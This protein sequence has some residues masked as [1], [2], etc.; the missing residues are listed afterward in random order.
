MESIPH[1]HLKVR[2]LVPVGMKTET[3]SN[4]GLIT[5]LTIWRPWK[6]EESP[7][8]RPIEEQKTRDRRQNLPF[9]A[10]DGKERF[11]RHDVVSFRGLQ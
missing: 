1:K 4:L 8:L 9:L 3:K 2:A 10:K 5:S 7:S 11:R 6:K